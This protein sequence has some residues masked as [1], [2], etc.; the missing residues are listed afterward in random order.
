MMAPCPI[1]LFKY[2]SLATCTEI[3]RVESIFQKHR[4]YF[5]SPT[6]F[7]DPFDCQFALCMNAPVQEKIKVYR[8]SLGYVGCPDAAASQ[9]V[10]RMFRPENAEEFRKWEEGRYAQIVGMRDHAGVF[11]L[12]AVHDHI[13]MWSHYADGHKGLCLEFREAPAHA[14]FFAQAFE[15]H[16]QATY[17]VVNYYTAREGERLRPCLLTKSC[18][19]GYEKE[20]RM[21]NLEG[22]GEKPIDPGVLTGVILA[23]MIA[24]DNR[25]RVMNWVRAHPTPITV[26]EARLRRRE[27]ALEVVPL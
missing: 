17:P 10:S 25:R 3:E 7:N 2:R 23:A 12:T 15:V 21:I 4:I 14:A 5:A 11:C 27:Y 22:P 19:W 1:R 9:E 20:Y 26:Y 8:E 18:R 16:Y 24:P 13:L 6:S